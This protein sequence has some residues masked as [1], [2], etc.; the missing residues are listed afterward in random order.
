[1]THP[2]VTSVPHFGAEHPWLAPLAGYTDLSFRLLCREHGAA[3]A[4]T[5][6]VSARGLVYGELSRA[7]ESATHELLRTTPIPGYPAEAEADRP[8]V[9]QLF[10]DDPE[11]LG[12]AVTLLRERGFAWFDLNMGCSVPKVTKAGAGTAL[13]RDIR[14]AAAAAA[15]MLKAAGEGRVGFKLRLGWCREEENYLELG[16]ALAD[17][18]AGWLTLHP[19]YAKQAFSGVPQRDAL[20]KLVQAVPRIRVMGSGDL[21]DALS[22]VNWLEE[23][24]AAGMMFARGAMHNPAIFKEYITL[25]PLS[26]DERLEWIAAHEARQGDKAVQLKTM[27]LRHAELARALPVPERVAERMERRPGYTDANLLKMR[28][29]VPRYVRDL[30]GSK[31]LRLELC[32]CTDWFTFYQ[33]IDLYF[34]NATE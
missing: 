29:I 16:K 27:I 17:L 20:K 7:G 10:G 5:E 22:A 11:F 31:N 32:R 13:A 33:L 30:P 6:M 26:P 19:R 24:G 8:L 25:L 12:Q 28:G 21:F 3:V 34:K 4:C 18:G 14:K 23:S 1:M 2:S 15:A 9:V